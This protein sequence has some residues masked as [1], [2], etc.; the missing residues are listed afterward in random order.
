MTTALYSYLSEVLTRTD[1]DDVVISTD[2]VHTRTWREFALAVNGWK[3]TFAEHHTQRA[4]IFF[5]DTFDAGAA[6]LGAW[7]A[8]TVAVLPA[9]TTPASCERLRPIVDAFVGDFPL[10]PDRAHLT[11][12]ATT[13]PCRDFLDENQELVELFTSG[14]TG[15][16]TRI[17]K[18]LRQLFVEVDS[19]ARREDAGEQITDDAVVV[20]TVSQQHIYGLLFYLL[21]PLASALTAWY[22]QIRQPQELL[23]IVKTL[24]HCAWVASPALL[25]RLPADEDWPAVRNHWEAIFSSGGPLS[26]DGVKLT[27]AL[28][29]LTPIEFLGSSEAGGIAS[30]Q[31]HL[32]ADGSV[33][34]TP[35][36]PLPAVQ[37]RCEHGILVIKSPQLLSDGWE[38]MNDRIEPCPDGQ[39]FIHLGRADNIVKIEEKR[40]SL[41]AVEAALTQHPWVASAKALQLTDARRS[42]AV[43]A[44]L[45]AAGLTVL[46]EH[47]KL[48]LVQALREHLSQSFEQVCLPRRWRFVTALPENSMGKTPL[49]L[50]AEL[51][52]PTALQAV[53]IAQTDTR[54]AY[55]VFVP[56]NSPFFEGHFPDFH[57]LPGLT[58]VQ[59]TI[60][61]ARESFPLPPVFCGINNLKLTKPVLPGANVLVELQKGTQEGAV[62]FVWSVNG[63]PC[64]K[65]TLLF[66]PQEPA[67]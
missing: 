27:F 24:P 29:G 22:R 39:S 8:G 59:W 47:G 13:T 4:A 53:R 17:I 31:R 52:A 50:L 49:A 16:P 20:S 34:N 38:T 26:E 19:I 58:Q 62:K 10:Q 30:R 51:F 56:G 45:T 15:T 2:G 9:D 23:A 66:C 54:A 6:L 3:L 67:A 48:A 36:K 61:L 7:A 28:T 11:P 12:A 60:E 35:W 37:W 57:L 41:P 32:A 64:A 46:Q 21:W 63:T 18:K 42:L 44:T 40:V 1:R 55:S 43:V 14:S 33:V 65:G 25:K 5:T